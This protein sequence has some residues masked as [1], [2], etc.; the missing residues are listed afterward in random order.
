MYKPLCYNGKPTEY[1][2]CDD[3]VIYNTNTHQNIYGAPSNGYVMVQLKI[4]A[5]EK[6][7]F[8]FHRLLAEHFIPN[9]ENKPIVHHIDGN[10]LNNKLDNLMWVTQEENCRMQHKVSPR[11]PNTIPVFTE[12]ELQSEIWIPYFDTDYEVS[13]LGRKRH[14]KSGFITTGS[15]SKNSGYIR[16]NMGKI[17]RQAHRAVYEAFHPDEK[18]DVINHIDG[19]RANNRLSNLENI[20]QS[21]NVTKSY[22]DTMTKATNYI[23]ITDSEGKIVNVYATFT[24]CANDIGAANGSVV[25]NALRKGYNCRGYKVKR[26]TPEFFR[27]FKMKQIVA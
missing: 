22:Y 6:K 3:G 11:V 27:E 19:N 10:P 1:I 14:I 18:I 12:E 8:S 20:S 24:Q 2:I 15:Q 13:S 23:A 25:R 7:S 16:W 9:P 17:E 5:N 26:I 21:E 4:G